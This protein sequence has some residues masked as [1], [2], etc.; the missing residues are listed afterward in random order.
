M[1]LAAR[2]LT[3]PLV[4]VNS[5]AA[6]AVNA[7]R[8]LRHA[9]DRRLHPYRR[10]AALA[11]LRAEPL[12]L[13]ILL[14]CEGNIYRSPFAAGAL[15]ALLPPEARAAVR[16]ASAG[17]VGPGRPA[18]PAGVA[19]AARRGVD[20]SAHRSTPLTHAAVYGARLV[21]VM[22]PRQAWRVRMRFGVRGSR[23]MV[24]GDLDP[25]PI[26]TRAIRDPWEADEEVLEAAYARVGR[27]AAAMAQALCRDASPAA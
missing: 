9:P 8:R 26:R 21:V 1:E 19:A 20:L 16:V 24:M 25:L 10:A 22:E 2:T 18:P 12:P 6:A 27:C 11:R 23:V 17:F 4:R 7:L 5:W 14:V 13:S 15:R 3:H